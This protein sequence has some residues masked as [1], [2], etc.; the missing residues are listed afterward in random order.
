M[1]PADGPI[2]V[3]DTLRPEQWWSGRRFDPSTPFG[4]ADAATLFAT[5]N[6]VG[7]AHSELAAL[8]P[9]AWAGAGANAF[10]SARD[11]TAARLA[12]VPSL[13]DAAAQALRRHEEALELARQ[14]LLGVTPGGAS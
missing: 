6:A 1:C 14:G 13:V 11:S 8:E 4:Y 5:A 2:F 3:R 9:D 10:R 7:T 12:A